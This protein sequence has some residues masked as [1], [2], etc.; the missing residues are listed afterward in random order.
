MNSNEE[1]LLYRYINSC[2]NITW[3]MV[4][5]RPEL[6]FVWPATGKEEH[7]NVDQFSHYTRSGPGIEYVVWPAMAL[8]E[9]GPILRKGT[10]QPFPDAN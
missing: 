4:I 5:Q 8:Y 1:K 10:V 7:L 2:I 6:C 3:R 9:N